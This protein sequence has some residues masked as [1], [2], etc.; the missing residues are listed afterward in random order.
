MNARVIS[1]RCKIATSGY[2]LEGFHDDPDILEGGTVTISNLLHLDG[3]PVTIDL[4]R[5]ELA[6]E[7]KEEIGRWFLLTLK[8]SDLKN[9]F[10]HYFNGFRVSTTV[11]TT[12]RVVEKPWRLYDVSIN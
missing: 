11:L 2:L 7:Q 10:E 9:P 1:N 8:R 3:S 12:P 6:P 4:P 5:F